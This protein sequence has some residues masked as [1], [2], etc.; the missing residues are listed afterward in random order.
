ML[1]I[2]EQ[3]ELFINSE[4]ELFDALN[5]Y[6]V[7]NCLLKSDTPADKEVTSV[8]TPTIYDAVKKIRFLTISGADFAAEP[9][10]SNLISQQEKLAILSNL[11]ASDAYYKMP[12]GFTL[13][14]SVR[15]D[16]M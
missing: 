10:K 5:R 8:G 6:A 11:V 13:D 4:L 3:D 16:R 12:D 7:K 14:T 9:M 1:T 15:G 2:F